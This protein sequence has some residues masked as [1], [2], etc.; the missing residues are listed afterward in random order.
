MTWGYHAPLMVHTGDTGGAQET[1]INLHVCSQMVLSQPHLDD[2]ELES[3]EGRTC[4]GLTTL[5]GLDKGLCIEE[6]LTMCFPLCLEE[7]LWGPRG[8]LPTPATVSRASPVEGWGP[9]SCPVHTSV[10]ELCSLRR[11]AILNFCPCHSFSG[12]HKG[13]GSPSSLCFPAADSISGT[14]WYSSGK[15]KWS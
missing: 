6:A 10:Q 12:V 5:G 2:E 4:W 9:P 3:G 8:T 13:P 11:R 1:E 7:E 14:S 15:A